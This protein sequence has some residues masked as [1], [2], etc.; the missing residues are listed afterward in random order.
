MLD[1]AFSSRCQARVSGLFLY[2]GRHAQEALQMILIIYNQALSIP[3]HSQPTATPKNT[4]PPPIHPKTII[5]RKLG[6][7][8]TSA[9]LGSVSNTVIGYRPMKFLCSVV[10]VIFV[11][12]V[13]MSKGKFQV[14]RPYCVSI[15]VHF[16]IG[17]TFIFFI[18][19]L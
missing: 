8:H 15:C 2:C 19:V 17:Q 10:S 11:P 18:T 9:D 1:R 13:V 16:N 14:C 4:H 5:R 6:H 3:T 7:E 12:I